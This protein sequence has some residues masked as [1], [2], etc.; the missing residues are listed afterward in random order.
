MN[1]DLNSIN[2]IFAKM[3]SNGWDI[4]GNLKWGFFFFSSE[5]G[6]L[7]KIFLELK[8]YSYLVENIHQIENHESILHASKIEV[9]EPEKLYRRCLAF[10]QLAEAYNAYFDG[11]DVGKSV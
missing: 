11:C 4:S 9:L 10:N 8:E 2:D 3:D 1:P 7:D 6:C 5:K